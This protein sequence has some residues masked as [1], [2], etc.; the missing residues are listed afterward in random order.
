M[1]V[2]LEIVGDC[3]KARRSDLGP[4]RFRVTS[5]YLDAAAT[6][7]AAAAYAFVGHQN[8]PQT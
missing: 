6:A 1:Q 8:R 3:V 2:A 5:Q 7:M 4:E